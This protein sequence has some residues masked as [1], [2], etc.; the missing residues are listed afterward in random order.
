[1]A[2]RKQSKSK[3]KIRRKL[4]LQEQGER[5]KFLEKVRRQALFAGKKILVD[6]PNQVKIS[7]V[8]LEFAAPLLERFEHEVP[9]TNIIAMA[10]MAW[11]LSLLP[12]EDHHKFINVM[13][14]ELS[15]DKRGLEEMNDV[16]KWLVDRKRRHFAEHRRHVVDYRVSD[17]GDQRQL[18][19][20]SI[21]VPAGP[22][23]FMGQK[24]RST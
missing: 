5:A 1:M 6:P 13:A 20:V 22:R 18:Q 16:M 14:G 11:N 24:E 21:S 23:P 12:D 3:K 15:L 7:D 2:G 10:I 19:V 4:K 9:V 8:L 17:L